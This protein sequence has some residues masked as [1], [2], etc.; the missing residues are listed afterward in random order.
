MGWWT[1]SFLETLLERGLLPRRRT[2][3][4]S[5]GLLLPSWGLQLPL[6]RTVGHDVTSFSQFQQLPRGFES[7]ER[8]P[9][10]CLPRPT[11]LLPFPPWHCPLARQHL[12]NETDRG[13]ACRP[14]PQSP[15]PPP[16][17]T[18]PS[19]RNPGAPSST[20]SY[21][22]QSRPLNPSGCNPATSS[23]V[24]ICTGPLLNL[25]RECQT[26]RSIFHLTRNI[27]RGSSMR[28]IRSNAPG[29]ET[30][31]PL[32]TLSTPR[33]FGIEEQ[34]LVR[35]GEQTSVFQTNKNLIESVEQIILIRPKPYDN[36]NPDLAVQ[37]SQTLKV[38]RR[39]TYASGP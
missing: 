36:I 5:S 20:P 38:G 22:A 7:P 14:A 4:L 2:T 32:S 12:L 29:R 24:V 28:S 33:D 35:S 8:A 37:A 1:R 18:L 30:H 9:D 16:L 11:L 3:R 39:V 6:G 23:T 26:T 31:V 21:Q 15:E 10:P 17:L 19:T 34:V 25:P 13:R 27:P